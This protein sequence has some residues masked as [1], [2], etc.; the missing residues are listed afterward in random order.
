M[1]ECLVDPGNIWWTAA[2]G[3]GVLGEIQWD[4]AGET[5]VSLAPVSWRQSIQSLCS[6][7]PWEMASAFWSVWHQLVGHLQLPA[8]RIHGR[9]LSLRVIND[10]GEHNLSNY[11]CSVIMLMPTHKGLLFAQHVLCELSLSRSNSVFSLQLGFACHV[12]WRLHLWACQD[13]RI[14][15]EFM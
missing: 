2:R 6:R 1:Q 14:R 13:T 8:G 11:W 4:R 7:C 10:P 15:A 9:S 3:G 12:K 5:P